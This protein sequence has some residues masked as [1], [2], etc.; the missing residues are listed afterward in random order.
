MICKLYHNKAVKKKKYCVNVED[1]ML[2]AKT[3][4]KETSTKKC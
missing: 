1:R 3:V 2:E 4:D